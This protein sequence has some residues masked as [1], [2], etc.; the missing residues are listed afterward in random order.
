MSQLEIKPAVEADAAQILDFIRQ[1]AEYE[2]MSDQVVATEELVRKN[3]FGPQRSA[4]AAIARWDGKPVGFAVFFTSFSTF[5][6][7]PCMYLEDLFVVPQARGK[8]I[9]KKLLAY[10]ANQAVER[11]CGRLDWAVLDWN[12]PSIEFYDSLDAKPL[13]EWITYRL[14]GEPLHRLAKQF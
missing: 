10:L 8:G 5:L 6:A 9:G 3:L 7:K 1:L 4:E 14:Q 11:G 2:K 13:S 12:K